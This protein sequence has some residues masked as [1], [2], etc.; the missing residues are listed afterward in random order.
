VGGGGAMAVGC[1]VAVVAAC[2]GVLL[3]RYRSAET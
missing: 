3:F 1:Y 2:I